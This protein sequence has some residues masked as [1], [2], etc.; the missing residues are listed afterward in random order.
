MTAPRNTILTG[1]AVTRLRDLGGEVDDRSENPARFDGVRDHTAR[2]HTL[3][4]LAADV[5]SL[6]RDAVA[7]RE[8]Q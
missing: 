8:Q 6:I 4:A 2:I 1:D 3:D 7:K 5:R